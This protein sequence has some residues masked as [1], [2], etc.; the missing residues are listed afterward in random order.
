MT[1]VRHIV[2][3]MANPKVL[4]KKTLLFLFHG[5][6]LIGIVVAIENRGGWAPVVGSLVLGAIFVLPFAIFHGIK[7]WRMERR[8]NRLT[9]QALGIILADLGEQAKWDSEVRRP[10]EELD[11][12]ERHP[13]DH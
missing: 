8:V 3:A 11:Q 4:G 13:K 7:S 9:P 12:K 1:L 6:L 2:A 5:F 10:F